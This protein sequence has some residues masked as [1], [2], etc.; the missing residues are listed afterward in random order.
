MLVGHFWEVSTLEFLLADQNWLFT[1]SLV[2][3]LGVGVVELGSVIL[4]GSL[5]NVVDSLIPGLDS[6][7]EALAWLHLGRLPALIVLVL[8]LG[9]FS[10]LGF[11]FQGLAHSL[12]GDYLS[13]MLVAPAAA[14]GALPATRVTAGWIARVFPRDESYSINSASF[15]GRSAVVVAGE[16][17]KGRAAEAKFQDEFGQ[18]HYVLVEP[19]SHESVL[20][21]GQRVLLTRQIGGARFA[22]IPNPITE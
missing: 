16:A 14:V 3:M 6:P 17:R 20:A 1:A 18:T 2:V 12:L 5:S 10:A 11:L 4:G 19:D 7:G 21:A 8:L 13:S 15:L 22:A 9:A